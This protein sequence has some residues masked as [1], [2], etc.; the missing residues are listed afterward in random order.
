M[1]KRLLIINAVVFLLEIVAYASRQWVIVAEYVALSSDGF[2]HWR[3]WQLITYQFLHQPSSIFHILFN[4]LALWIFGRDVESDLGP[5]QFLRL[6]FWGGIIG[7]LLW[8]AFN[9]GSTAFVLGASGAVLA[10]CIAYATLYPER[11]ITMLILFIFPLTMKA[12]WWAWVTVG[13]VAYSSLMFSSS[14]VADLAHLGGIV[15]GYLYIKWLGYGEMPGWM[16]AIQRRLPSGQ[17]H[18]DDE[19]SAHDSSRP[20]VAYNHPY[21]V[22]TETKPSK[23]RKLFVFWRKKNPP[24]ATDSPLSKEEFIEREV[25]PIL[26]KIA[27]Q[28]MASLSPRERKILEEAGRRM[29]TPTSR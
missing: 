28:G 21:R 18:V 17:R 20:G 19:W 9:F 25:N 22:E 6:Y 10:V 23:P 26:D 16:A 1:V 27:K 3:V 12:K 7:G 13:L 14:S 4:M 2:A 5:R 24:A 8:L 11:P 29:N 15:V